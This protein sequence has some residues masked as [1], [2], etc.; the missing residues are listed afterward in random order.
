MCR[1]FFFFANEIEIKRNKEI[2]FPE[3]QRVEKKEGTETGEKRIGKEG[4]SKT[5]STPFTEMKPPF[6]LSNDSS[7]DRMEIQLTVDSFSSFPP[8]VLRVQ[9]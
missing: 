9:Q 1:Q 2:S 7:N 3:V 6:V 4:T 8:F 5:P